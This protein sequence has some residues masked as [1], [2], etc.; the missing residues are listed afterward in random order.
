MVTSM[1][2]ATSRRRHTSADTRARIVEVAK[3]YFTHKPFAKVSL[4]EIAEEAGVSAPLIIKYFST[5]EGLL[6]ERPLRPH[7]PFPRR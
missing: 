1:P 6:Q 5:K 7:R 3:G 4:K 2:P